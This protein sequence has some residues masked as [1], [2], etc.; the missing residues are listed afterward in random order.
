MLKL[1]IF[2]VLLEKSLS[3]VK[4]KSG[5]QESCEKFKNVGIIFI[6]QTL[7]EEMPLMGS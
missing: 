7:A 5:G 3:L 2:S 1:F 4:L 6:K